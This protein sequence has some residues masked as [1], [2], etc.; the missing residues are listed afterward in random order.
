MQALYSL[1]DGTVDNAKFEDDCRSIIGTQSYVL[2]T[3]DKLIFKLVKQVRSSRS[4]VEL[5]L[6]QQCH[7]LK[8]NGLVFVAQLQSITSDDMANK[9]LALHSYE[10]S[11]ASGFVDAVYHAN[12]ATVL[13]DENIYRFERVRITFQFSDT[14]CSR[15]PLLLISLFIDFQ[16]SNPSRLFIQ[17]MDGGAEKMETSSHAIESTFFTYLNEFLCETDHMQ[18]LQSPIFLRR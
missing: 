17:L 1:L 7:F 4:T 10:K 9:L 11:R 15:L 6:E 2:F 18:K 13:Q 16:R 5:V 14:V 12:A 8:I 3:M